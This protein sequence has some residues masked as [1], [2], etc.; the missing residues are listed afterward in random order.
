MPRAVSRGT[1]PQFRRGFLSLLAAAAL[2]TVGAHA[3]AAQSSSDSVF[4]AQEWTPRSE[5][6]SL[7][8]D[9]GLFAPLNGGSASPT[10]GIRLSKL[11]GGHLQAGVLSGWTFERK[12][13]TQDVGTLPGPQPK[14]VL[15]RVD[16]YLI[17]L[18]GYLRVNFTEKHWLV[19]YVGVGAGYEWLQIQATD[20]QAQTTAS[21]SY[22]NWAWEGWAGLGIRLGQDLRV[23]GEAYYNGA[24]LER[25]VVDQSGQAYK[26]VVNM[27]GV[28]AR[29]GLDIIF[30]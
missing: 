7:H 23:N 6:V 21:A 8:L 13:K 15:A 25:D 9:G 2:L 10:V 17:P 16:A 19:P 3:A 22:S 27:D 30:Q 28:G 20:Y 4:Y 26:E 24:S 29:V 18:M 11:V 5:R 12:D 14:I 1:A